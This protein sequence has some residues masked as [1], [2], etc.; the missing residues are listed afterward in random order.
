MFSDLEWIDLRTFA[1]ALVYTAGAENIPW[2]DIIIV[3]PYPHSTGFLI[4]KTE[5]EVAK[6]NNCNWRRMIVADLLQYS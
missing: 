3:P 1:V 6:W 5:Y 4:I 2:N